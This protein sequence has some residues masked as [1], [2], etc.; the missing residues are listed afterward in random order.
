M[1]ELSLQ[2]LFHWFPD[3]VGHEIQLNELPRTAWTYRNTR[4]ILNSDRH[5]VGSIC[6]IDTFL[7]C[8][9]FSLKGLSTLCVH[10]RYMNASL[11]V[12]HNLDAGQLKMQAGRH[13]E[14]T[15][16]SLKNRHISYNRRGQSLLVVLVKGSS[17][18]KGLHPFKAT[19]RKSIN[20]SHIW[21]NLYLS[22]S[23]VIVQHWRTV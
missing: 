9:V 12:Q 18:Q 13:Q 15:C 2:W 7:Q 22:H 19:F 21:I 1:I 20:R 3:D 8:L 5:Q 16:W 4:T 6:T 17:E 11:F 23:A 10:Y 14:T